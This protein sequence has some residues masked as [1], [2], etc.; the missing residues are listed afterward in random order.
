MQG[1][2]LDTLIQ[3]YWAPVIRARLAYSQGKYAQ[4]VQ[5]LAGTEAYDL[6]AFTTGQCMDAAYLLGEAL[7]AE[8][9]GSAAAA[10]FRNVLA[11]RGLV[12]NCPTGALSQLGL[13]RSLARSGDIVGSRASYQDLFVLWKRADKDF[14]LLRQAENEY[15][16]LR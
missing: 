4:A 13:A 6:G 10:E 8:H 3:S 15:R 2:P 5:T 16:A 14:S 7:L 11:H 9:Q 12:L 1:H